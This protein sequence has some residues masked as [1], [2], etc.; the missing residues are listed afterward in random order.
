MI[1]PVASALEQFP[2][3]HL[4][5]LGDA[6]LDVY[7]RGT[8]RRLT[9]EGPAPVV[10]VGDRQETPGGAANVAANA[11]ALGAEAHLLSVVGDDEP[12]GTLRTLLGER[13][14]STAH[15]LPA[16]ERATLLKQ[17]VMADGQL[18]VRLD[19]GTGNRIGP[20]A[21]EALI[22]HLRELWAR[23]DAVVVSDY[24]Y[25]VL[26][27]AVIRCLRE[28]QLACPRALVVDAKRPSL[29]RHVGATAVKPNYQQ[30]LR[31]LEERSLGQPGGRIES[32]DQM[33]DRI[34]DA[35]GAQVVAVTLDSDGSLILQRG[36]P[37]HRTPS[38]HGP[39][40]SPVGAG[41]SY[42]ATL[43]L[44]LAAGVTP[45][46]AGDMASAASSVVVG[47]ADTASCAL[48]ELETRLLCAMGRTDEYAD[49]AARAESYR[50]RGKR[51]VFTNGCFD[52]V[53]PGHVDLLQ[54]ARSLGDV[55]IVGLNSDA[56]VRRLKG[57]D[58]P[59]NPAPARAAVLA[60]LRSVD[61]VVVFDDDLPIPL[62]QAIRPDVYVKGADYQIEDL[63]EAPVVRSWGGTVELLPYLPE[64]STTSVVGRIRAIA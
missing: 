64:H 36:A 20:E 61:D 39:C 4:L 52:L 26:T 25:G 55:L 57:T 62:I 3:L 45:Q 44:A 54:R 50:A 58:R 11:A 14:V 41:D 37:S 46:E 10:D 42:V 24:E 27:P 40:L 12:G 15:V 5:V 1:G 53:H 59:V 19:L 2:D 21:E 60:A 30:V 31:L 7:L 9:P 56:S 34:L 16:P 29:Y 23:S 43:A 32:I 17:R 38:W 13:R 18:L 22:R 35:A 51:I 49:A 28:L 63:P 48:G 47:K 6:M 8:A 33:R